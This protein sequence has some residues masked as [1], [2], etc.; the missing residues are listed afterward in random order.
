MLTLLQIS[1]QPPRDSFTHGSVSTELRGGL[2][3]VWR[4]STVRARLPASLVINVSAIPHLA[5]MPVFQQ[6]MLHVGAAG[7]GLLLGAPGIGA[8]VA[9]LLPAGLILLGVA[10]IP[11]AAAPT[12][13]LALAALVLVGGCQIWCLTSS[14]T[15]L[16]LLVPCLIAASCRWDLCRPVRRHNNSAPP[17][18]CN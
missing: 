12:F 18:P 10:L 1:A 13:P 6:D 11:F 14:M 17:L 5:L 3:Y 7:L 8:L 15:L 2:R 9:T 16:H 4:H